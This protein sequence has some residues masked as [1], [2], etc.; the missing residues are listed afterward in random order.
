MW[1]V[2]RSVNFWGF[3]INVLGLFL[4]IAGVGLAIRSHQKLKTARQAVRVTQDKLFHHMA[5]QQF[6]DVSRGAT[7][8]VA[9]LR[10]RDWNSASRLAT[11]V[12]SSLGEIVGA[13][14]RKLLDGS[15]NDRMEVAR[16]SVNEL[17]KSLPL[18]QENRTVTDDDLQAMISRCRFVM[19]VASEI[20]GRLR[21]TT[22]AEPEEG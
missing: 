20:G 4:G 2:L 22:F 10:A 11:A 8:L 7:E 19:G 13:W 1:P 5:A 16:R 14:G 15:E 21:V 9:M 12:E 3:V 17:V 6:V 18:D